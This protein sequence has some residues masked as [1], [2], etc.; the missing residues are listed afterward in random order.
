MVGMRNGKWLLKILTE[1]KWNR[2]TL[3]VESS[4]VILAFVIEIMILVY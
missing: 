2:M 3:E 1:G 4:D